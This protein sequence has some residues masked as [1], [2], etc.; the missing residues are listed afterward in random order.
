MTTTSASASARR[1][2][3]V[4]SPTSPGPPPTSTTRPAC[5]RRVPQVD[6]PLAQLGG[7]GVAHGD[8]APRV[9][10]TRRDHAHQDVAL[11]GG[12]GRAGRAVGAGAGVDAERLALRGPAR[13][14]RR[15]S[16]GRPWRCAPARRR[17]GRTPP[18]R[19]RATRSGPSGAGR[20]APRTAAARR[21]PPGRRRRAA[22]ARGARPPVR[23]RR[24]ARGGR[25]AG[26][27]AS[28]SRAHLHEPVA[29][30]GRARCAG[31][32]PGPGP[33]SC[34]ATSRQRPVVRSNTCLY[35][36]EATVGTSAPSTD[37]E[38]TMPREIT[39]ASLN[40]SCC[41]TA[42]TRPSRSRNRATWSAPSSAAAP[43]SGARSSS[44]QPWSTRSS[45]ARS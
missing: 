5:A 9:R 32:G 40:G 42:S 15:P 28:W 19:G 12:R 1:P 13:A 24:R 2:A 27:R 25:S 23:H 20:G 8:R 33:A 34:P 29:H 11:L 39:Y 16:S 21:R 37:R 30:A 6:V 36:G 4:S 35:I 7:D 31:R 17:R 22:T 18:P 43:R 14:R 38:P 45:P 41:W 10:R 26:A 3:S 44:R